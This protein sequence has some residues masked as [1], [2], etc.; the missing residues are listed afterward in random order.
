MIIP[1][2]QPHP[3]GLIDTKNVLARLE[4]AVAPNAP[5][6][7]C[8]RE[9]LPFPAREPHALEG[10]TSPYNFG[11]SVGKSFL[12]VIKQ[13]TSFQRRGIIKE[14]RKEKIDISSYSTKTKEGGKARV[15][16]TVPPRVLGSLA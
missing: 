13:Q 15:L 11:V 1:P 14:K 8:Q 6:R 2:R 16:A 10:L 7:C 3:I 9:S 4:E 12:Y 5:T